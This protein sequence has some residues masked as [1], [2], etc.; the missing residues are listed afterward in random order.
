MKKEFSR[1]IIITS[2]INRNTKVGEISN[3]SSKALIKKYLKKEFVEIRLKQESF[4][5]KYIQETYSH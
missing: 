1:A 4:I 2:C 3:L 5:K